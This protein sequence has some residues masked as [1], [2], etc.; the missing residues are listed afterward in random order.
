MAEK[1]RFVEDH[2]AGEL[3][4]ASPDPSPHKRI[5][6]GVR[7][8]DSAVRCRKKQNA[9][10]S[11]NNAKFTQNPAMKHRRLSSGNK[12]LAKA[13]PVGSV[14]GIG[15]RADD[16]RAKD[17]RQWRGENLLGEALSAV[18]DAIRDSET[19]LA[20]LA[21]AGRCRT[22]TGNAG[23][24]DIS[25]VPQSCSST[26]ASACQGPP[27]E[28]SIYFS[29][30]PADQSQDVLETAAGVVPGLAL[31]EYGPCLVGR[32]VT[33]DDVS[34]TTKVAIHPERT[35]LRLTYAWHSSVMVLPKPSSDVTR[36]IVCFW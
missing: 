10:L 36:W 26:A 22:L 15:L 28:F 32:T 3:I 8:V 30:A 7:N 13:S 4:M 1:A 17:P 27:S 19:G 33:R 23:I 24:H 34:F 29:D 20:H 11:G 6:R 16:P 31:S 12:R 21:S 35:P 18:R 5:G 9:V 25:S 14:W 2:R